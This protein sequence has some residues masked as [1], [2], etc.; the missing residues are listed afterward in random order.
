MACLL[1]LF[2]SE[3]LYVKA[4]TLYDSNGL[5]D[6][7]LNFVPYTRCPFYVY[8]EICITLWLF[9]CIPVTAFFKKKYMKI[10]MWRF[11]LIEDLCQ[12]IR[13]LAVCVFNDNNGLLS[14]IP[15]VL[16]SKSLISLEMCHHKHH[17][18]KTEPCFPKLE[19]QNC[20]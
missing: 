9:K 7:F 8:F 20:F 12:W 4:V 17:S 16:T 14:S 11:R 5:R 3:F 13:F 10:E 18:A 6:F 15:S 2:T 1:V 19:L